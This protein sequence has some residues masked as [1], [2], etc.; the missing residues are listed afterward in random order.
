MFID[1]IGGE[2][3]HISEIASI[4][5]SRKGYGSHFLTRGGKTFETTWLT[6]VVER[7]ACPVL[8]AQPGFE[9]LVAYWHEGAMGVAREPIIGW[10]IM[11][12]GPEAIVPDTEGEVRTIKYPDGQV[13]SLANQTFA[14]E[15]EWLADA[16]QEMA[17]LVAVPQR[18][19]HAP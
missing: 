9:S 19:E 17:G 5:G 11:L 16:T 10:R 8:P 18:S 7:A 15:A 2:L 1:T 13:I 6:H 12:H 3:V 4:S 14:N